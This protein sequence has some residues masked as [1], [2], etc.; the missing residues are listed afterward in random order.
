MCST[1]V[2]GPL[3][4]PPDESEV[5]TRVTD[6]QQGLAPRRF[7]PQRCTPTAEFVL[8]LDELPL[9]PRGSS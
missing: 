8:P 1:P 2:W 6:E 4:R 3:A 9:M 7:R 5:T